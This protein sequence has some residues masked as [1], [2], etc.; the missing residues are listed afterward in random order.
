MDPE[1]TVLMKC[2][3][4]NCR[5]TLRISKDDFMPN[6]TVEVHQLCPRH[7]KGQKHYVEY[8]DQGGREI[9]DEEWQTVHEL[10]EDR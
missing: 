3:N 6:G 4:P 1:K 9:G 10:R 8:Y 5:R 2:L 7:N